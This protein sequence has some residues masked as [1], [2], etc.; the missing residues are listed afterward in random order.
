MRE[1]ALLRL[2]PKA[3]TVAVIF[4]GLMPIM[5]GSGAGPDV[6]SRITAPM[7][8]GML[9][10]PL[11]FMLVIPATYLLMQQRRVRNSTPNSTKETS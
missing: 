2:R 11:L 6:M 4:A 10:A 9:T 8:G 5:V 1:G 3:M 7:V